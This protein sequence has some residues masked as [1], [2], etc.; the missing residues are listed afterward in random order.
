MY[1]SDARI[2]GL[3]KSLISQ[4]ACCWKTD[5]QIFTLFLKKI[6]FKVPK[7]IKID[8][9]APAETCPRRECPVLGVACSISSIYIFV[10]APS[11]VFAFVFAPSQV[12][13][14]APSQVFVFVFAPSQEIVSIFALSCT[15]I[16]ICTCPLQEMVWLKIFFSS[17][18]QFK[19]RACF[20]QLFTICLM[21]CF[22]IMIL[23]RA[24]LEDRQQKCFKLLTFNLGVRNKR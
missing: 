22:Q 6:L 11:Q 24:L 19:Q 2:W 1:K 23:N 9:P 8:K 12:F 15:C 21:P 18:F 16:C 14:F 10:F 20:I 13:V 7:N 17:Y 3:E 4:Q 5:L